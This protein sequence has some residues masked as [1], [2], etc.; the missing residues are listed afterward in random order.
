LHGTKKAYTTTRTAA[1]ELSQHT[2]EEG[3]ICQLPK[4]GDL[5]AGDLHRQTCDNQLL[6]HLDI[7]EAEL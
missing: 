3:H 4:A 6:W 2:Y 7:L 1:Q 5:L